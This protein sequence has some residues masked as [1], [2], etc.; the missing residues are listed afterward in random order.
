MKRSN[1]RL[2]HII[3]YALLPLFTAP[4][5]GQETA[6]SDIVSRTRKSGTVLNDPFLDIIILNY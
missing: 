6:G 1:I 4:V 2:R 5:S 3:L